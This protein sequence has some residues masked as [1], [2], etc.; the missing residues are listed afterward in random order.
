MDD[1]INRTDDL[2]SRQALIEHL[3]RTIEATS[4]ADGDYNEGF[5]DGMD[6]AACFAST[7]PSAQPERLTDDDLETIR[8][9][10]SAYKEKLCNQRRWKE[11]EEY[12]RIIDRLI[13][14]ASAQPERKTGH[15]LVKQDHNGS[16]YGE[17]SQCHGIQYAGHTPYCPYCGA[18]MEGGDRNE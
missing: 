7:L 10:L 4:T 2:I 1:L 11:A 17:C 9:H 5:N 18:R 3:R 14:F 16:T 13:S 6:F 15:W 8:I 12:Q